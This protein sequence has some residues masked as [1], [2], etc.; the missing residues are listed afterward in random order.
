MEPHIM[1]AA[2][3]E[4]LVVEEDRA[5]R[6]IIVILLNGR[7]WSIRQ[8]VSGLDAVDVYG[9]HCQ[10]IDA[11]LLDVGMRGQD[12]PATLI[13]LQR[14]NPR[15]RAYFM[16]GGSPRYD[17]ASLSALSGTFVVHKPYQTAELV[18]VLEQV[19]CDLIQAAG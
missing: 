6:D 15:V 12:G 17:D 2:V 1:S 19:A 8:A 16:T 4:V 3:P 9:R 11:V 5:V 14:I 10:T 7:G 13:E 18:G